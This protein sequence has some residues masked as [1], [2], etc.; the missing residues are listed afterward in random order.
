MVSRSSAL[1]QL[2]LVASRAPEGGALDAALA[3][4]VAQGA[5]PELVG[6]HRADSRTTARHENSIR[7]ADRASR[8]PRRGRSRLRE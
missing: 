6:G 8:L 4:P 5:L 7:P 1:A 2:A 3:Q